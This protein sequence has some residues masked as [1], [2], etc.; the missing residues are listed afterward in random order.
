MDEEH[1]MAIVSEKGPLRLSELLA[2]ADP[3]EKA[4]VELRVL[5][6]VKKGVL[7]VKRIGRDI[8]LIAG[9]PS[10]QAGVTQF[11]STEVAIVATLPL[12]AASRRAGLPNHIDM[13]EALTM[14]IAGATRELR[15][16]SPFADPE[17]VILLYP[18]F[19]KAAG[20]G[21]AIKFLTRSATN[22]QLLAALRNIK[23]IYVK[24]GVP[25]KFSVRCY[26]ENVA[27]LLVE[28]VHAKVIISDYDM[29]YVGSGELRKHS[30]TA[31]VE[32]GMLVRG[33]VVKELVGLF[34]AVWER[35]RNIRLTNF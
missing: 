33:A 8:L 9:T 14:L 32:I 20:S 21:V 24:L 29:A 23:D 27:G 35:A 2:L 31:N 19:R 5:R 7:R 12:G 13:L 34:D 11:M 3:A 4:L 10:E 18:S 25:D 22:R 17:T 28:A 26:E 30:L 1:I 15:I 6:M 16:S